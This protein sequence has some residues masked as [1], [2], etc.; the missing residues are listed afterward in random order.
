MNVIL[1]LRPNFC[2]SIFD[3]HKVYE[4]RKRVFMRNDIDNV[5]IYASKPICKIVGYFTIKRIIC[6]SPSIVWD[7]THKQGGITKKLFNDYFKGHKLAH[8]IEIDE[9]VKFNTPIDPMEV[10]KDFT[11]LQNFT[12]TE[13]DLK[14]FT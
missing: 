6:D 10:I 12:Y 1:S 8:A 9:V 7:M 14:T 13:I 2:Q 4:Y 3:G 11:P 5:Y